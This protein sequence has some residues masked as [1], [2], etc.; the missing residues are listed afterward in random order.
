MQGGRTTT[1]TARTGTSGTATATGTIPIL[2]GC[3]IPLGL[4]NWTPPRTEPWLGWERRPGK[5]YRGRSREVDT[6]KVRCRRTRSRGSVS[7]T[8]TTA[9][10]ITICATDRDAYLLRDMKEYV[11]DL[12]PMTKVL[13]LLLRCYSNCSGIPQP[14]GGGDGGGEIRRISREGPPPAQRYGIDKGPDRGQGDRG[15]GR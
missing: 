13:N 12:I 9:I 8:T 4:S 14:W 15:R 11:P 7:T 10:M 5:K 3:L 6:M 1:I 2:Y